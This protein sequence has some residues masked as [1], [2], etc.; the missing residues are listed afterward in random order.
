MLPTLTGLLALLPQVLLLAVLLARPFQG[1]LR[2]LAAAPAL[3]ALIPLQDGIAPA[4]MLRGLWGDPS[5]TSLQLLG[6]ALAGRLP[7][8]L[9]QDWRGPAAIAGLGLLFYPLALGLGDVNPYRMGYTAWP[10]MLG[11]GAAALLCWWRGQALWLWLLTV[12]LLAYAA[13]LLESPNLW[14]T[15]LDPLLVAAMMVMALRNGW[16]AYKNRS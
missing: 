8:A 13:G 3:A 12:N 14:D 7:S 1:R 5:I 2:W 16:R 4:M 11:F 6:L 9:D 15:L 10:L